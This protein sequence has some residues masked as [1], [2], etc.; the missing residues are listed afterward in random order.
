V[1][2]LVVMAPRLSP[3]AVT[4]IVASGGPVTFINTFAEIPGAD[5]FN[6]DNYGGSYALTEHLLSEG[7][8]R[9]A[10][11][12]GPHDARDARDRMRGVRDA[13]ASAGLPAEAVVHVNGDYTQEAGFAATRVLLEMDP[14]PTAVLAANDYCAMGVLSGLHEAGISVPGEIAVAGFDGVTSSRY[15]LPPLT[16]VE[17]PIRALGYRALK[18]LS[19]RVAG[20]A[21]DDAFL[22]EVL[23]AKVV[24]RASTGGRKR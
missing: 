3:E 22:H 1:D 15:T 4:S 17:V 2:G 18:R 9:L 6:F 8:R 12:R 14:R 21:E 20:A 11:V 16:T 10:V 13:V 24:V 23:P 5:V 7:H 19:T